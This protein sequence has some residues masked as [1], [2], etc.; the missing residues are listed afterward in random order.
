MIR[1]SAPELWNHLLD[2]RAAAEHDQ[3][4]ENGQK[5]AAAEE[6]SSNE[7]FLTNLPEELILLILKKYLESM[8]S[9]MYKTH[10]YGK[11][12]ELRKLQ[13]MFPSLRITAIPRNAELM[14]THN[15]PI[16]L[17]KLRGLNKLFNQLIW[18]PS[19]WSRLDLSIK[20]PWLNNYKPCNRLTSPTKMVSLLGHVMDNIRELSIN[21]CVFGVNGRVMDFIIKH[22]IQLEYLDAS[23]CLSLVDSFKPDGKF[24][25]N[26]RYLIMPA[27]SAKAH[28][29][30]TPDP[31]TSAFES[32]TH[33]FT[34]PKL[35]SLILTAQVHL[36]N[37]S[38]NRI[39]RGCPILE[40]L[41]CANWLQLNDITPLARMST[42]KRLVIVGSTFLNDDS[43][44]ALVAGSTDQILP[45][46]DS[47]DL[48]SSSI[49]STT[50]ELLATH[51]N[52]QQL[53][54][55][56]RSIRLTETDVCSRGIRALTAFP[57]LQILHIRG[58]RQVEDEAVTEFATFTN[59]MV[60]VLNPLGK[61]AFWNVAGASGQPSSGNL[62]VG[63]A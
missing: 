26:P 16:P 11:G 37:M 19:F 15:S 24:E 21:G 3:K 28:P 7:C 1:R 27:T 43:F 46:L 32:F 10:G 25:E 38:L 45:N 29:I 22:G 36:G 51:A 39:S 41:E 57:E 62:S 56:L 5:A 33:G 4:L 47:L 30:Q 50:V 58:C 60:W 44:H 17:L 61:W 2:P 31:T 49:T 6:P 34:L 23:N 63:H 42:L 55:T 40:N 52:F 8:S 12:H 20:M 14:L 9:V 13:K 54:K 53:R 35:H 48:T 18:E 59:R